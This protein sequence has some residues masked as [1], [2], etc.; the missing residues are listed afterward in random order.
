MAHA[1]VIKDN[2]KVADAVDKALH[3]CNEVSAE[4]ATT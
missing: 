3:R 2:M 1:D 4:I